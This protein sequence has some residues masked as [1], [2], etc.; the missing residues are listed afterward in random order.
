MNAPISPSSATPLEI[1]VKF[2]LETPEAA[3]AVRRRLLA[4]SGRSS[5]PVFESNIRFEDA[6]GGLFRRR[7]LLRLRKDEGVRLTFKS[8]TA[9]ANALAEYKVFRELETTVGDF[10]TMKAILESLGFHAEQVYEKWRETVRLEKGVRGEGG[11]I[12]C[13]LDRMPFGN[14]LEIEG[15]PSDIRLL[16]NELEMAWDR[17]IL[18][19]YLSLFAEVRRAFDLPFADLTFAHFGAVDVPAERMAAL[20]R[21]MAVHP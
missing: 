4:L 12:E 13:C 19:N 14:F 21:G 2:F 9:E 3:D 20:L 1:E 11:A 5:G 17:R 7:S 10:D 16:A 6:G 8:E 15:E 18:K